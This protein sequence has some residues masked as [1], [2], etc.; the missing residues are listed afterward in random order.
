MS[1]VSDGL[2]HAIDKWLD[3]E[4]SSFGAGKRLEAIWIEKKGVATAFQP[5]GAQELIDSIQDENVFKE[6]QRAQ[7]L[8]P[9]HF[10]TNR[11]DSLGDLHDHLIPCSPD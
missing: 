3:L 1:A 11:I 7:E 2:Q 10:G 9:D 6:C 4:G 5:D 8:E